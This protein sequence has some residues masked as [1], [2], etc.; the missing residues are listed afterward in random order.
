MAK[1]K[2]KSQQKLPSLLGSAGESPM[3]V[4]RTDTGRPARAQTRPQTEDGAEHQQ[5]FALME[6]PGELK[7]LCAVNIRH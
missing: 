4:L 2:N 1:V 7:G 5:S 6:L 3:P